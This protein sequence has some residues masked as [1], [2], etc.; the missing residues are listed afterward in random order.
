MRKTFTCPKCANTEILFFPWIADRDD[1][2]SVRPLS[3]F[4]RHFDWK[5]DLESGKLQAYVCSACGYTE[6]YTTDPAKIPMA[7]IPG[8][9]VLRK[10]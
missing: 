10:K 3:I 5:D 8:A 1:Q 4:V 9:K 2:D 6:L 7:K